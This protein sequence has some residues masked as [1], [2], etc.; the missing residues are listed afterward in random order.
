MDEADQNEAVRFA[1][2]RLV[3]SM[4]VLRPDVTPCG[5][6]MSVSEAH[7]IS[8]LFDL[9]PLSQLNLGMKLRLE[10]STI[11]RLVD[12]LADRRWVERAADG[13][14]GRVSLVRL[15]AVGRRRAERLARAR[16]DRFAGLLAPLTADER[17]TMVAALT[18]LADLAD[19]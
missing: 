12:Q 2:G 14:D 11:S 3:R 18:R 16:R 7:C 13:A 9:G 6:S 1:F 5:E 4:G 8:E 19:A 17:S 10:K 15:T